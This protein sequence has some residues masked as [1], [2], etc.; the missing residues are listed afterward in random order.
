VH[1]ITVAS[2]TF[3]FVV[4]ADGFTPEDPTTVFQAALGPA[5]AITTT[6]YQIINLSGSTIF[7]RLLQMTLQINGTAVQ[8]G[9]SA[10]RL[11]LKSWREK[12][13]L[14]RA[15]G[16]DRPDTL[17]RITSNRVLMRITTARSNACPAPAAR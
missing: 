2:G 14:T 5:T 9:R 3:S 11:E 7:G 17:S 12:W 16:V 10:G 4:G 1:A 15:E 13:C 8:L 6:G